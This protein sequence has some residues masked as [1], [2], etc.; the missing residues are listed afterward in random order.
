MPTGHAHLYPPVEVG[1]HRVRTPHTLF[2]PN[3]EHLQRTARKAAHRQGAHDTKSL[4]VTGI[5]AWDES[6]FT[7]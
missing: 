3:H 1:A 6:C 2:G 5:E 4:V 7:A